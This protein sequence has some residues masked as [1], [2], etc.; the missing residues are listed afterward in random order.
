[1]GSNKFMDYHQNPAYVFRDIIKE[2]YLDG[3]FYGATEVSD[4]FDEQIEKWAAYFN[5]EVEWKD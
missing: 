2:V 4:D 3:R 5:E 1:M